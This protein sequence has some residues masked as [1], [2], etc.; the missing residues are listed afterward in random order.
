[1]RFNGSVPLGTNVPS[2]LRMAFLD[3]RP[4]TVMKN[5]AMTMLRTTF[6]PGSSAI[7]VARIP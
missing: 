3:A 6:L 5:P 7:R 1:M 2:A 4:V